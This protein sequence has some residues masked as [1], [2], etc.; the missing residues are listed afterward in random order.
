MFVDVWA[1]QNENNDVQ[2]PPKDQLTWIVKR[3][4]WSSSRAPPV[5]RFRDKGK[6]TTPFVSGSMA[7]L[8]VRVE[9]VEPMRVAAARAI[10]ETPERDAWQ[11]LRAWAESKGLL[12]HLERHPVYGFNNPPPSKDRK[13]Y[14]YEMWMRV[15][16]GVA[17]GE[18]IEPKNFPGGLYAVT[19]GGRLMNWNGFTTHW[20]RRRRSFWSSICQSRSEG[21]EFNAL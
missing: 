7:D 2:V 5:E 20:L 15:D 17:G 9:R 13:E 14:G 6:R 12:T 1:G 21:G 4:P 10:S 8:N 18:G 11:R 16:P 19:G 3:L